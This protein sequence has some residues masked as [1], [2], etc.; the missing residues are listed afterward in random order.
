MGE[1]AEEETILVV[2][3]ASVMMGRIDVSSS[4]KEPVLSAAPLITF[5]GTAQWEPI[6]SVE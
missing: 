5:G 6:I 4:R 2:D 1:A 3:V